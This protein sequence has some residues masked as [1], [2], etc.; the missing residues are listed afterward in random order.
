MAALAVPVTVTAQPTASAVDRSLALQRAAPPARIVSLLP[1]LTESVCALGGCARLVGTDRFSNSPAAV[2]ALPKL[3]G[4]DD[5]QVERIVLLQPDLVLA[6]PGARVVARLEALGVPVLALDSRN[7]AEVQH[8]L[9]VL[10]RVLGTP[11][12][13]AA[14]S[15]R[16]EREMQ[17]A[18]ARVP[19]ALRGKR[20]YFEVDPTPHAAGAA[21]FIGETLARLGLSNI[22]PAEL[23][24]FPRLNPE[25][26]L[27]AQPDIVMTTRRGLDDMASRPGWSALRALQQRRHCGFEVEAYEVLVRPGPRMGEAALTLA[28]CL[29]RLGA[30]P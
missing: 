7:L 16:I 19:A 24:P 1:S 15:A 23:G 27:R 4:L 28:D 26:V 8:S 30:M 22:A 14:V 11:D 20:V 21:S 18:A 9:V 6:T 3:G 29:A 10:A 13:A 25:F 12:A 2:L 5:A 17:A